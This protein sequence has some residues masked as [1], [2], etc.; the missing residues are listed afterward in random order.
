MP[1]GSASGDEPCR[2][3]DVRLVGGQNMFQG[4]VEICSNGAWGTICASATDSWTRTPSN[5]LA[6]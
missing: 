3:Y 6:S 2:E 5:Y 1:V 4:K